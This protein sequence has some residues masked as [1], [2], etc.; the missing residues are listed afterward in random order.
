L[1]ISYHLH[2]YRLVSVVHRIN[3]AFGVSKTFQPYR[4]FLPTIYKYAKDNITAATTLTDSGVSYTIPSGKFVRI[5]AT[6]RFISANPEELV[7]TTGAS[8]F[9]HVTAVQNDNSFALT[10]TTLI[11]GISGDT[12]A[13]I[14]TKCKQAGVYGV[15]ITVES[16]EF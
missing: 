14:Y 12:T 6:A 13:K 11:G 2:I 9:A 10:A 5:T 15:Y 16:V 3:A 1:F 4:C 7:I 8:V